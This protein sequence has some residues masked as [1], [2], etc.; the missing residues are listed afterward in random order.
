MI[1]GEE[2]EIIEGE[3][4]LKINFWTDPIE[5]LNVLHLQMIIEM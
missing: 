4:G 1:N 2:S 3:S 5:Y